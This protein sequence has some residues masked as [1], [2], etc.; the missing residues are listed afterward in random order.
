M[1]CGPNDELFSFHTGG[2]HVLLMDGT[3][4]FLS[5]SIDFRVLR[6]LVTR[7]GGEIVGDF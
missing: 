6:N 7:D 1:N 5:D 4:R 3:V 2:C